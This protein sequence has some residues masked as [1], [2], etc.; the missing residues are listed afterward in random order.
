MSYIFIYL[1][2]NMGP[3]LV[4]TIWIPISLPSLLINIVVE[5][6]QTTGNLHSVPGALSVG[7]CASCI[8]F[9]M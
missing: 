5:Y 3:V 8:A 1:Y 2:E 9:A 6:S 4:G 7:F